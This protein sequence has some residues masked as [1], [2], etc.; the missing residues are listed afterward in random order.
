MLLNLREK[1]K[2]KKRSVCMCVCVFGKK[3]TCAPRKLKVFEF[4][5]FFTESTINIFRMNSHLK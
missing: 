2:T 4:S 3:K 1:E 5:E